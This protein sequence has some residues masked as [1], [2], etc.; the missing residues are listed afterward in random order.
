MSRSDRPPRDLVE[1]R[2]LDLPVDVWVR[3]QEH[4]DGLLREFTLM[5]AGA[6]SDSR[7]AVPTQLVTLIDTLQRD[8]AAVISEQERQIVAASAAGDQ[9]ID[10]TYNVPTRA[11]EAAEAIGAAFDAADD[12]CRSGEHLLTLATPPDALAFRRWYLGEFS[13]QIAGEPPLSWPQWLAMT[14]H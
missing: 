4:I 12:F 10:L 6:R 3:A 13:R 1:V 7:L 14:V 5:I 9:S 2:I 11:A 8:Y